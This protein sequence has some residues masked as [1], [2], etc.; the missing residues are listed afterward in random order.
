[1]S[2]RHVE[3]SSAT[4]AIKSAGTPDFAKDYQKAL[5]LYQA[6]Q[7]ESKEV[8]QVPHQGRIHEF[9]A[10]RTQQGPR[11]Q[12]VGVLDTAKAFDDKS[13]YDISFN[14]S[15]QH[16]CHALALSEAREAYE[17]EYCVPEW[18]KIS[19]QGRTMIQAWFVGTHI[20]IGGSSAKDGLSL[21]P[22]Q[23][24]LLESYKKGL[25]LGFDGSFEQ[26]SILE[27]SL[28]LAFPSVLP[29]DR[30]VNF[31]FRN[32][33]EVDMQD[34]RLTHDTDDL[35]AR[36]KLQINLRQMWTRKRGRMPVF[37]APSG[38]P[39]LIGYCEWGPQGTILHP[40]VYL[41]FDNYDHIFLN[42]KYVPFREDI[43]QLRQT[44]LPG[45]P[46]WDTTHPPISIDDPSEL[47]ILVCGNTGIGKSTL[48]NAVFGTCWTESMRN[49]QNVDSKFALTILTIAFLWKLPH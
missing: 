12:Y 5:E 38:K 22:L 36:H 20:D 49:C 2:T 32:G 46:F 45:N 34:I 21:Y 19:S 44:F 10:S 39:L 47:R 8:R 27:N 17:P 40:S 13:L 30:I 42:S 11:T 6:M 18:G 4:R 16:M 35:G 3:L 31:Q 1:M 25:V 23:W 41:M 28:G 37:K 15:I 29:T 48:V 24:M 43:N 33:I 9:I 26:M 7:N 14:E